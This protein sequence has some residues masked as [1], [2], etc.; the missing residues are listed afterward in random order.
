M[1]YIHLVTNTNFMGECRALL[2]QCRAVLI[3]DTSLSTQC[4]ALLTHSRAVLIQYRALLTQCRAVLLQF[5]SLPTSRTVAPQQQSS[6]MFTTYQSIIQTATKFEKVQFQIRYLQGID[7][8]FR[9]FLDTR[10]SIFP[11]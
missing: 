4:R 2:T 1:A 5:T 9:R 3:H 11:S 7:G 6:T 8:I 10:L